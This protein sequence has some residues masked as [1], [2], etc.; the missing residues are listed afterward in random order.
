MYDLWTQTLRS[1]SQSP[2][3]TSVRHHSLTSFGISLNRRGFPVTE[4]KG[5][6]RR[7]TL[8]IGGHR[9]LCLFSL[10]C[11]GNLEG[12]CQYCDKLKS[13][14]YIGTKIK[15]ID[16]ELVIKLSV[17]KKR[18][19]NRLWNLVRST[20]LEIP[21][22]EKRGNRGKRPFYNI[23]AMLLIISLYRRTYDLHALCASVGKLTRYRYT[24]D[25]VCVSMQWTNRAAVD[26]TANMMQKNCTEIL[27]LGQQF[28]CH[29][30]TGEALNIYIYWTESIT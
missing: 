15:E 26:Q 13:S 18:S 20:K 5:Y 3:A 17:S 29:S 27:C 19:R 16:Y 23:F 22:R 6:P 25:V 21:D 24:F 9:R 14:W 12:N 11:G 7:L 8:R 28:P 4:F 30:F 1:I 10:C 2:R